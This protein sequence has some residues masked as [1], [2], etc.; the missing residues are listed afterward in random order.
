MA[1]RYDTTTDVRHFDGSRWLETE[2]LCF[3]GFAGTPESWVTTFSAPQLGP[4]VP[5]QVIAHF[6]AGRGAIVYSRF[7]YPLATLGLE[8]LTRTMELAVRLRAKGSGGEGKTYKEDLKRL[9]KR[10][11]LPATDE[12]A[13]QAGRELR[14]V[15]SHP[16]GRFLI[17][18]GMAL[19]HLHLTAERIQFLFPAAK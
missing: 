18:P 14:N 3:L 11:V 7:F 19:H 10:G 16:S 2:E 17:D 13:W 1:A 5:T 6:E 4:P 9:V 8:N 12:A 15:A